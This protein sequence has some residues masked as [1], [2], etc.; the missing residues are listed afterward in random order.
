MTWS[1]LEWFVDQG[2]CKFE[3]SYPG[4]GQWQNLKVYEAEKADSI[5]AMQAVLDQIDKA[6]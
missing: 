5:S 4:Q 3:L 2:R 6:R 1:R